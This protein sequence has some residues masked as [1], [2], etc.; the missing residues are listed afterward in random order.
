MNL[1]MAKNRCDV[2][3]VKAIGGTECALCK[4]VVAY[5]DAVIQTN[6][7]EAAIDAALEKVCTI[8]P[9]SLHSSCVQFVDTF[10]PKLVEYIA[11]YETP[12]N[13]CN[14]IGLCK[15]GSNVVTEGRIEY[16]MRRFIIL[17]S[18]LVETVKVEKEAVAGPVC[19]LC[20]FVVGYVLKIVENNKSAA[21]I[22]HALEE[23]CHILPESKRNECIAFVD[24]YGTELIELIEKF[25]TPKLV[26]A[27]LGVCVFNAQPVASGKYSKLNLFL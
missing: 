1:L 20:E 25:G 12:D 26:C 7:S 24:K 9:H 15:N 19:A 23:V 8:A 11:K 17:F 22:E 21:A 14:A 27:A 10:G 13:V 3:L 2:F 6:Q 18:C 4:Y 16:L 5:V